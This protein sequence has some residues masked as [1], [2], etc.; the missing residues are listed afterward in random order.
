[1]R[2]DHA[3]ALRATKQGN[4]CPWAQNIS[5]ATLTV[6]LGASF[7]SRST[8]L[9]VL[10]G[11]RAIVAAL[12]GTGAR[13]HGSGTKLTSVCVE[14]RLA[15]TLRTGGVALC[16][17]V[18]AE[19]IIRWRGVRADGSASTQGPVPLAIS[20]DAGRFV[21]LAGRTAPVLFEHPVEGRCGATAAALVGRPWSMCPHDLC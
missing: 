10:R 1:M 12:A 2:R 16:G 14:C 20:A 18:A 15:Y 11:P 7:Y 9:P 3:L 17:G 19:G 5:Y 6:K 21:R 8:D 13:V 4:K